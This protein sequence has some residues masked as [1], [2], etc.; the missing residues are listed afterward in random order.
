MK[1]LILNSGSSSI[2]S[3]LFE[4]NTLP[5]HPLPPLW[6]AHLQW[7]NQ[8]ENVSLKIK[9]HLSEEHSEKIKV[10]SSNEALKRLIQSLLEGKKPVL[11]SLDEIDVIGHRIVHGGK[12]YKESTLINA[13]VKAKIKQLSELAPLH[14]LIDLEGIELLETLLKNK[15]QIA[16]FDTAFHHTLAQSTTVY[17]G[18][19]RW[20]EEGIQRFGFHGISFQYCSR[21]AA[22]LLNKDLKSLKMLICHLGS[23][24]SL[25]AVKEGKSIDTTMGFTPLEGLMM[26]TRS[27]TIDPGILLYLMKKQKKGVEELSKELYKDSGLLGISGFSSDMRDIIDKASH[28]DR[29]AQLALEVYLHRLNALIGSMIASLQGMD[30]LVFTAGIGEN[31]SLIRKSVCDNF[32][33]LGLKLDEAINR[34][35]HPEDCEISSSN[36]RIK[37]LLI[38][39]DEAF[40]I[41]RECWKKIKAPHD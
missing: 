41:A 21:R 23:G 32:S 9:N 3:C 22:D 16:V 26:D 19:Y 8:F 24:A 37:A 17:P 40:E 18:P 28:G 30:V 31:A 35:S 39:T 5:A 38:H 4:F 15:P 13:N 20:F 27:G 12:D 7:K 11:T 14:N 34:L 33:F 1:I 25:C 2:K 29:R 6:E 36:S 10:T